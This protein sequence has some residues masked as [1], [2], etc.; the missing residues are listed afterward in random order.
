MIDTL[1]SV[2]KSNTNLIQD[3]DESI[4]IYFNIILHK[5]KYSFNNK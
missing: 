5:T 2:S 1:N 3:Y 4:F